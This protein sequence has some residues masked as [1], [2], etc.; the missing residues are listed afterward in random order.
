M[1]HFFSIPQQAMTLSHWLPWSSVPYLDHLHL[2][3]GLPARLQSSQ[4][5]C[6][7]ALMGEKHFLVSLTWVFS[8]LVYL[9][10]WDEM[11]TAKAQQAGVHAFCT[12]MGAKQWLKSI[13]SCLC[14]PSVWPL[15]LLA[16][17]KYFLLT[18][19][20][21]ARAECLVKGVPI[22]ERGI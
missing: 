12:S 15:E 11:G 10:K 1:V 16:L 17:T 5:D 19:G 14:Y 4:R 3:Q 2:C 13:Q 21:Q 7:Q 20:C 22:L 8:L 18:K 9:L 6:S